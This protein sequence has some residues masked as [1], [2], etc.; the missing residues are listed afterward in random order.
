MV[1]GP[2]LVTANGYADARFEMGVK[3][4][5]LKHVKRDGTV[6]KQHLACLGIDVRRVGLK[7]RHAS[8]GIGKHH[9]EQGRDVALTTGNDAFRIELRQGNAACVVYCG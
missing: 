7:S 1:T 9:G 8:Y 5:V 2:L 6:G 4:I 3:L